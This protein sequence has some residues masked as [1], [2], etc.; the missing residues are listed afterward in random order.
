MRTCQSAECFQ[1]PGDPFSEKF[2][3]TANRPG[4]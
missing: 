2:K 4:K 3:A 1:T